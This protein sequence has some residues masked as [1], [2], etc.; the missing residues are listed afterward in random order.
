VALIT[1]PQWQ[2]E[3]VILP[4]QWQQGE[5]TPERVAR[6]LDRIAQFEPVG[7]QRLAAVVY[8]DMA[9]DVG[10]LVHLKDSRWPGSA[11]GLVIGEVVEVEPMHDPQLRKRVIVEPRVELAHVPR[12]WGIATEGGEPIE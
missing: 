10:D 5:A 9:V 8:E 12:V 2:L 4:R 6:R 11:Q 7:P 1:T 3:A